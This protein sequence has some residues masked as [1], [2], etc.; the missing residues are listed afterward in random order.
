MT[1]VDGNHVRAVRAAAEPRLEKILASLF[2]LTLLLKV[3]GVSFIPLSFLVGCALLPMTWK[4]VRDQRLLRWLFISAPLAILTGIL[5]EI[6]SVPGLATAASVSSGVQTAVWVLGFPIIIGLG[7]WSLERIRPR[8]ALI[9]VTVGG[10]VGAV[11]VSHGFAWKGTV[12]IYVTAL[13]LALFAKSRVLTFLVLLA[14]A[15]VSALSD[16][17]FMTIIALLALLTWFVSRETHDKMKRRRGTIRLVVILLAAGI[18]GIWAMAAGV[19]GQSVAQR[20]LDQLSHPAFI[21]ADA[22]VEWAATAAL[23]QNVP[24][25]FGV[26]AVPS[27]ALQNIGVTAVQAAGGDYRAPYFLNVV[28]GKRVDL[29][30]MLADLWFHFSIGGVLVAFVILVILVSGLSHSPSSRKTIGLAGVYMVLVGMWDLLFSPM[31]NND[32]LMLAILCACLMAL[33]LKRR[34]ETPSLPETVPA[35]LPASV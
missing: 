31:A 19:L 13:L 26:S 6:F 12:G 23:F 30:S 7:V 10:L 4:S 33:P 32:R 21:V 27:S 2:L 8:T 29:H 35:P 28:F 17:R 9:L 5:V 16:A 3:P 34:F 24:G 1:A 25:G 15:V 11:A 22:R 20:T 14:S 18:A